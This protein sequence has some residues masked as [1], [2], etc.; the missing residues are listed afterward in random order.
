[1]EDVIKVVT[2]DARKPITI[3]H[4]MEYFSLCSYGMF[5]DAYNIRSDQEIVFYNKKWK[6]FGMQLERSITDK[7]DP[8]FIRTHL[9]MGEE[10]G[11]A[12]YE[13]AETLL[14]K[15]KSP[16]KT[17]SFSEGFYQ[18][19]DIVKTVKEMSIDAPRSRIVI[20]GSYVIRPVGSDDMTS[21]G[22]LYDLLFDE[23][24]GRKFPSVQGRYKNIY[25]GLKEINPEVSTV[26]GE[27]SNVFHTIYSTASVLGER[28]TE[29]FDTPVW[30]KIN[31]TS[32][33]NIIFYDAKKNEFVPNTPVVME[34]W[35]SREK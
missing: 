18:P 2:T 32:Q 34:L 1:M 14:T 25:I 29:K 30:Y 5:N 3:P 9:P 7:K 11:D 26:D 10:K 28:I 21:H 8:E 27:I 6:L 35:L 13:L 24:S 12:F 20:T 15:L 31:R 17:Y 16:I 22:D 19:A 33:L 4:G 23:S